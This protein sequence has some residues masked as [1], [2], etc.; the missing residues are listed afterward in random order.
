MSSQFSLLPQE[1]I[2]YPPAVISEDGQY[3][4][5]LS[6]T[7]NTEGKIVAIVGLNPSIA[8]ASIDDPTI[9]R[10]CR[11]ARDWGGGALWMVNLFA[12][13]STDPKFL[14]NAND[15]VGPENDYWLEKAATHADIL[16]AAWGNGGILMDRAHKIKRKFQGKLLAL[17]ITK[18]GMPGH[19]L[20][21]K[22]ET[23]PIPYI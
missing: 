18:N 21:I 11:F 20:Y 16:V 10:C 22:A 23:R 5:F 1:K 4:Y 7:W 3:R 6:R 14:A 9:R 15:P 2:E 12:Y 8:D 17:R 13:R 19:P